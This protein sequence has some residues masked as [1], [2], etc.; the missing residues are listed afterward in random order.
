MKIDSVDSK[1]Q[2]GTT[3]SLSEGVLLLC[4]RAKE[5]E[6]AGEIDDACGAL[7]EFWR[8]LGERPHVAGLTTVARA[9]LLLR[10][11]ALT[12][13]VGSARQITGAQEIAKDLISEAA[14][15][16]EEAG[17]VERVAEARVDLAICYWREGAFDEA[18]VSL[19]EALTQLGDI[20]SEQR[21]RAL[22]NKAIVEKVSNRYED[23]L[24]THRAAAPLFEASSNNTLRGK[25]HNEYATVLK[26]VGLAGNR[27]DYIDQALVEFSAA[28]FHAE[29]VGNKRF[30]A[31][32]EN[33]VGYLFVR[34]RRFPEAHNHLDR[35][36]LLFTTLK[37]KGMVAQVNDTR[38][39]AFIAQGQL[40]KAE[41]LARASVRALEAGD[42]LSLLAEALM[43][44]GTAAARLGNFSK[45]RAALE[46]AIRTAQNAGDPESGG[47]AALTMAEELRNHLPLNEVI[48]YY[49]LAE[50]ELAN[51]QHPE[52][53][54]RLGKCARLLFAG[55]SLDA[56]D[57]G[58][59]SSA[60]NANGS[61]QTQAVSAAANAAFSSGDPVV[62]TLEEQVLH[63]EG[64]LI[65]KAL[66]LSDGSVTRAARLLG[67]THQGL[68]FI[69]NGRQKNLLPARKPVKRR[70]R[71]IIRCH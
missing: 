58:H 49:H 45:A 17:L 48:S 67:I 12:G 10:A 57:N 2:N 66:D 52:I 60:A 63:F 3:Y 32:V 34:L 54:N 43:T 5:L 29:Q 31:L 1:E 41:A 4:V 50:S 28:S 70:R 27:E 26:N 71:S 18:R 16:F 68:A 13:W 30:L 7:S 25:F 62:I 8:R 36:R 39:R 46:K 19:D 35:A 56:S 6:E 61:S 22:L 15:D 53:Q 44:L 33:N 69:L 37:D 51:S 65:K 55:Q 9:S 14:R 59:G 24:R 40:D 38:A 64:D 21:L 23:A 11:G 47:V 20:E 42:E